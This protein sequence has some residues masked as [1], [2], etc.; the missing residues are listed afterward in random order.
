MTAIDQDTAVFTRIAPS[1]AIVGFQ[2]R[3]DVAITTQQS[4][5]I[6]S[7]LLR[8]LG[9]SMVLASTG[10][11]LVAAVGEDPERGLLQLGASVVM[12]FLG[13]ALLLRNDDDKGVQF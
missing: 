11:W 2:L 9:G 6:S 13:L 4:G 10:I 3:D 8:L 12:L 7:V 1:D 5:W